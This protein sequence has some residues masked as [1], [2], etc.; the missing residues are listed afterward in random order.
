LANLI[1]MGQLGASKP[2]AP[3]AKSGAPVQ[4][5]EDI[6]LKR[7]LVLALGVATLGAFCWSDAAVAKLT[8]NGTSLSG[9]ASNTVALHG[10]KLTLPNGAELKFR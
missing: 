10:V 7:S 9:S 3:P 4:N 8:A 1:A 5:Q 2:P 6:M